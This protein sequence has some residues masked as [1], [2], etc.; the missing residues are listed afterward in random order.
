MNSKKED[1]YE[2][3]FGQLIEEKTGIIEENQ[4][5]FNAKVNVAVSIGNTTETIKNI[6]ELKEGSIIKLNKNVDEK[7]DIY[8]NDR[9][10]AYGESIITNDKL[11]VR[12]SKIED[13]D[14]N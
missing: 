7:L 3:N 12:L 6:L 5:V 4:N 11:S 14:I 1:I 10:F 13:S 2:L 9:L 8:A